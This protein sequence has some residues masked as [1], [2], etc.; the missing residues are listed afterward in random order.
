MKRVWSELS[1]NSHEPLRKVL[2]EA[3][4]KLNAMGLRKPA[5]IAAKFAAKCLPMTDMSFCPY[6]KPPYSTAPRE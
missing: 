4:D 5:K 1:T 2:E 3:V 6:L